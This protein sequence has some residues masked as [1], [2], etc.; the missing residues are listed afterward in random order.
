[1][2]GNLML[3]YRSLVTLFAL[4][5]VAGL[6]L[7]GDRNAL[8]Q[9]LALEAPAEGRHLWLHAASNGELSSARPV[10][11]A[12]AARGVPL[13]VTCNSPTGVALAQSWGLVA[14]LAPL[15]LAR[16]TRRMIRH[17]NIVAQVTMESELWPNRML[18]C[19]GPVLILGGRLSPGTA[20][21][22]RHFGG[23]LG[24]MLARVAFLSA[25]DDGSLAR[26]R[27]AGL[28]PEA[29]GPVIDLKAFYAPPRLA[30][31]SLSALR[32][33]GTWLAAS[34]HEG[35][36]EIVLAAHALARRRDPG[37]TL[38]LAPRHPRRADAVE[39]LVRAAGLSVARRTRGDPPQ[40]ADVYLADTLGEMALFYPLAGRVFI[41]GTLGDRGGHTPHEPAAFGAALIHGPDVA[42]FR[43]AFA[44]LAEQQA[45]I[46]IEDAATLAAALEA[47]AD[48]EAQRRL[49]ARARDALAPATDAGT[50]A[51]ML[52][53]HLDGII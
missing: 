42:N 12:L 43:P 33:D 50:L 1:M 35:E 10:I 7:R 30:D 5:V 6:V 8:R 29:E 51:G 3:L 4:K 38:I 34:T 25:Q 16:V 19:P 32:R 40:G 13:L 2:E 31:P 28:P 26:F 27:A 48:P 11:E 14:R 18:L 44:R 36:E 37:L 52:M 9:R 46:G 22:W 21:G 17:W 53:Q 24:R 39:R 49:G 45:A 41:G 23:L 15:D 47:L 20:R